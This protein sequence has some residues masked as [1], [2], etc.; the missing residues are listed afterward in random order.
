MWT[1][2]V[3]TAF[4]QLNARGFDNKLARDS[5]RHDSVGAIPDLLNAS[6]LFDRTL[7]NGC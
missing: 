6:A 3:C 5:K 2:N 1:H 7:E 4:Q